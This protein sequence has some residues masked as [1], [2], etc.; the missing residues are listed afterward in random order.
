MIEKLA[1]TLTTY[2]IH[3][4]AVSPEDEEVYVYGWSLLLSTIGSTFSMFLLGTVTGEFFGTLVYLGFMDTLRPYAGG[5]HANT[6][7]ACF[8]LTMAS[9]TIA[10][11]FALY[12][13]MALMDWTLILLLFSLV[14]TFLGAPVEHPNKPLNAKSRKRNQKMSRVIILIQTIIIVSLWFWQ[15]H[16]QHYLLWAM[17]GTTLTSVT[18]LYV[19]IK[20]YHKTTKPN[21]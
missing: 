16:L 4:E 11:L 10:L 18:L 1:S 6:Y 15:P 13:P 14:V 5:Y 9:Y 3:K 8:L 19:L 12:W 21:E 17:L 2:M 20:P 7:R